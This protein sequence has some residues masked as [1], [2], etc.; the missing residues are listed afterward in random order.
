VRIWSRVGP[1]LR[2]LDAA[3]TSDATLVALRGRIAAE[4]RDGL[5]DGLG[6]LLEQRG[7]LRP[8][9]TAERAGDLVYAVCGRANYEALVVECG[10]SETEYQ[11]WLVST[12]VAALLPSGSGAHRG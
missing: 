9:L 8:G 10:W 5:R 12:L 7:A 3:A 6:K 2:V 11:G 1:L 4:R